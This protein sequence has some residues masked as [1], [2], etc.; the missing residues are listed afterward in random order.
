[1][2]TKMKRMNLLAIMLLLGVTG[3]FSQQK[4]W[5]IDKAHTGILFNVTH[6]VISEVT[7]YFREF[8][9]K[10]TTSKDDFSDAYVEVTIKAASINTDNAQRDT[11]LKSADFFEVEKYPTLT[12][13]SKSF[14]KGEEGMYDIAGYLTIKGVTKEVVLKGK[15]NGSVN[16]KMGNT[17][18]GWKAI[19]KIDRT[20]YGVLYNSVMDNG[21]LAIGKEVTIMINTEFILQK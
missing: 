5:N 6:M 20:E 13:K 10:L 14:T 7:G 17:H 9:A 3:V 19:T 12:F 2:E 16:D 8:D 15:F 4:T 11:H 18:M 21:G 1:M